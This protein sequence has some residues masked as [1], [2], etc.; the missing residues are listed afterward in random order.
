LDLQLTDTYF[1]V[2][3]LHYVLVGGAMFPLFGAF[4]YW[5]PKATGR[6]MSESW[7]K[8]AFGLIVGGFNLGFFPMH[9]L[10][11]MGMPRRVYT[12]PAGMGWET[13]NQVATAGS[14]VAVIGGLIFVANALISYWHGEPSGSDPWGG[15]TLEW[16]S[17]SP[18]PP[19]NLPFTPVVEDLTP[20]WNGGKALKAMDGLS[21]DKRQVLVTSV[22]DAEPIY[23]QKSPAPSIW[24]LMAALAVSTMFIGSIFTPWA[25]AL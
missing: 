14:G 6:M 2:A 11:L 1:I 12:Y 7:G 24:P 5:Y 8:I 13:L 18:P 23:R 17:P 10:G 9:V 19:W 4:C 16:A 15:S 22:T 21:P 3:H 25:I 20:M